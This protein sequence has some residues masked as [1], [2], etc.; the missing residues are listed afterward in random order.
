MYLLSLYFLSQFIPTSTLLSNLNYSLWW[1]ESAYVFYILLKDDLMCKYLK[2]SHACHETMVPC[3]FVHLL[4]NSIPRILTMS[5][6]IESGYLS[7][8]RTVE[9]TVHLI[10][11]FDILISLSSLLFIFWFS[12]HRWNHGPGVSPKSLMKSRY[13]LPVFHCRNFLFLFK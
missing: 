12:W 8:I 10:F 9:Y 11:F 5:S 1:C 3:C 13:I 4:L 7:F 2:T 6:K